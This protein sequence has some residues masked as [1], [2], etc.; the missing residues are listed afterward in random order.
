M[1]I[2]RPRVFRQG[3]LEYSV[4]V[5]CAGLPPVLW[6]RLEAQFGEFL[7]ELSDAPLVALLIP[8]MRKGDDIHVDGV[9][10]ERL[11]YNLCG[12]YQRLMQHVIPSLRPVRIFPADLRGGMQRPAGVAT[13]F[14]AGIDSFCVLADHHY[15]KAGY[16]LT[17]LLFN[18]VGSHGR[19]EK[20]ERLFER[21]YA[22]T[23]QLTHRI[24]LPLIRVNSNVDAFY[25]EALGF[26]QTH[27]PRNASVALLLQGGIG[28]YIYGSGHSYGNAVVRV[29]KDTAHTDGISLPLLSTD[30]LD[31]FSA[32]M[33]YTRVEKTLRVSEIADSHGSLDVCTHPERA[34]NCSACQKCLRTLLT[35]EV[36]GVLHK[37]A[38][39]FDLA[40]YKRRRDYFIGL[41]LKRSDPLLAEIVEFAR[42]RG[43][44]FP[45]SARLAGLPEPVKWPLR[46]AR[47]AFGG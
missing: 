16:K 24:G 29:A 26:Q 20:G 42:Q 10:S 31:A 7:T 12:P 36:A 27:T 43:F 41:A 40:E 17:H 8:A 3:G 5:D 37:Y 33:Q 2:G 30:A 23:V 45:L 32:G 15:G 13:G 44:A 25:E 21:R 34:G 39:S 18:N 47:K 14:S 6:Y 38:A 9:I 46:L 22:R 19:E 28:R 35:L 4:R 11:Y 1:K